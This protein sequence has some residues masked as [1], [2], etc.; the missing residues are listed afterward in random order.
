MPDLSFDRTAV[1]LLA[2]AVLALAPTP[3]AVA[4][5]PPALTQKDAA[6]GL[7]AALGQGMDKAVARLGAPDGFLKDP[8]YTIPLPRP[9]ARAERALRAMGMQG[10]ADEL[11]TAMNRAAELAVVEARPV[12]RQA[13]T[14]MT[15]DDA[16]GILGGGGDAAT[17]YFRRATSAELT[18][19]FRPIVAKATE[20]VQLGAAYDRYAG[21]AA[22]LGLL[23]PE[24]AKLE[25][26]VTARALDALFGAI[27]E[28]ERAIRQDPMGQASTLL[29]RVFGAQ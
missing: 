24:D 3:A 10:Q 16:R 13:L 22:Q 20:K 19:R 23:R 12:F 21:Q 4:A 14:S 25:D 6:A 27:A 5:T 9:L 29:R 18:Q 11:R 17:Q 26:Y 8:R 28:E 1:R 7:R 2:A 15:L